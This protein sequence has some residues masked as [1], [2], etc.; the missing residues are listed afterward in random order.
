MKTERRHELKENDLAHM[1]EQ[2][3]AFAGGHAKQISLVVFG[4]V[5]VVVLVSVY[6]RSSAAGIED[7]W[8]RKTEL[9]FDTADDARTGLKALKELSQSAADR[10]FVL[11]SLI[12]RGA[13]SLKFAR[14]NAGG[15]PDKELNDHAREAY[16]DLLKQF[17]GNMLAFGS[18]HSGLATVEENMF[19]IDGDPAHKEEARK[20]LKAIVDRKELS[21]TPFYRLANDRLT[22]L[23]QVFRKIEFAPAPPPAPEAPATPEA[24]T[25]TTGDGIE[26]TPLPGPPPGF[27]NVPLPTRKPPEP[28]P[29]APATTPPTPAPPAP[30][31]TPAA[32]AQGG[33]SKADPA[34][35]PKEGDRPKEN[36]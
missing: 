21:T 23:D 7:L 30:A 24:K 2:G 32:P 20:H 13:V 36:P 16:S 25:I 34:S 4:V 31:T 6:V 19:V 14:Q 11:S 26:L 22:S 5:A 33:E 10:T 3:R 28:A 8:R 29:G 9:K 12:E 27:E 18:A 17:S 35:A 15:V 1:L